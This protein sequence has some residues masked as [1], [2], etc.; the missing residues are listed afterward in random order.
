M[1][2]E[3]TSVMHHAEQK[4]GKRTPKEELELVLHEKNPFL[5][6]FRP[7]TRAKRI[8]IGGPKMG[9][10][11]LE[12]GVIDG[13]AEMTKRVVVDREEFLKVFQAQVGLFFNLDSPGIKVLTSLWVEASRK[14]GEHRLYITPQSVNRIAKVHGG[15]VSRATFYRGRANLIENGFIAASEDQH[16]YWINPAI[17][18]NGDRLKLVQEFVRPPAVAAPGEDFDE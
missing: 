10:V 17:F 3:D 12:T 9:T 16:L 2:T 6:G 18:F 15:S 7:D 13:T 1:A 8:G 4:P 11:D 14:P 5:Q